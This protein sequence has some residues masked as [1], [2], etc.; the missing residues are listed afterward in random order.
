MH[1]QT[2]IR[3]HA[4]FD[5]DPIYTGFHNLRW[6]P[7][8]VE[9]TLDMNVEVERFRMEIL[10]LQPPL[11]PQCDFS[12]QWSPAAGTGLDESGVLHSE[13]QRMEREQSFTFQVG[14]DDFLRVDC[15]RIPEQEGTPFCQV[16]VGVNSEN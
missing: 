5:L 14:V 16:D 13:M 11:P 9:F 7:T 15:T 6:P 4:D 2:L 12:P 8:P 3:L 10:L 1:E